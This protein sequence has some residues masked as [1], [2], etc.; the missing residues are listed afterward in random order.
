MPHQFQGILC[1]AGGT[2]TTTYAFIYIYYNFFPDLSTVIAPSI[3]RFS[4]LPQAMQLS[5]DRGIKFE[6]ATAFMLS[7]RV[8]PLTW[9]QQHPQQ[10]QII[11]FFA[12]ALSVLQIR[13]LSIISFT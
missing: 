9:E 4:H 5:L 11:E 8:L 12:M 13:P 7:Q 3:Q 2:D 6:G 10:R 1:A